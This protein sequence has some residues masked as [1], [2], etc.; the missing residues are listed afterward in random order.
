MGNQHTK[1]TET[2]TQRYPL[3]RNYSYY[4]NSSRLKSNEKYNFEYDANGNLTK[5]ETIVG[6]KITWTYEY[7]VFNRL[8]QVNKDGQEVVS[9]LY[10]DSGLRIEKQGPGGITYYA[11]DTGRNVL[12]QQENK[13]Y[14][15][16]VYVYRKHFARVDGTLTI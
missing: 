2:I 1:N 10:D 4:P 11:F 7:D 15:E 6:Q 16:Y 3:L 5:K 13:D 9:Y 14:L 12:Y 8:S